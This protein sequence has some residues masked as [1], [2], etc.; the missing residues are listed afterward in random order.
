MA[1]VAD[2]I[3]AI[4]TSSS[5]TDNPFWSLA[6]LNQLISTQWEFTSILETVPSDS[7][8]M[9]F[10]LNIINLNCALKQVILL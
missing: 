3:H 7:G 2:Y 8:T 9:W 5:D 10:I 1:D 6:T 4:N